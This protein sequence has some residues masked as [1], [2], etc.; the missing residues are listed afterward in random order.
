MTYEATRRSVKLGDIVMIDYDILNAIAA[1][2]DMSYDE[3]ITGKVSD[4][5]TPAFKFEYL[6]AIGDIDGKPTGLDGFIWLRDDPENIYV[7][8]QDGYKLPEKFY[9]VDVRKLFRSYGADV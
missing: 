1:V 7:V 4:G 6:V 2:V 3:V 5:E 8:G 9:N